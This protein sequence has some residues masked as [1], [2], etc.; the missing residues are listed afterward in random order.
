MAVTY[1]ENQAELEDKQPDTDVYSEQMY[2]RKK[3]VAL[4]IQ[5]S[6]FVMLKGHHESH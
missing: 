2:S 5:E 4:Q 1:T 6:N 3:S